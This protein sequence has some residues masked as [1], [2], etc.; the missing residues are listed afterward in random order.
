M[1]TRYWTQSCT[2][3]L[4]ALLPNLTSPKSTKI[5]GTIWQEPGECYYDVGVTVSAVFHSHTHKLFSRPI[6]PKFIVGS[7]YLGKHY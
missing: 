6:R 5:W 4:A 7:K 3:S 1:K 2:A